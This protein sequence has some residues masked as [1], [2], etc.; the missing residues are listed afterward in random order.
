M[1]FF[2]EKSYVSLAY[3][4][5]F[6][7]CPKRQKGW[8][9]Y[10]S[11]G[12]PSILDQ[13]FTH[14]FPS[15]GQSRPRAASSVTLWGSTQSNADIRTP[16]KTAELVWPMSWW[17]GKRRKWRT[18]ELFYIKRD[19]RNIRDISECNASILLGSLFANEWKTKF[20]GNW[21]NLNV[22]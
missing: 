9:K 20:K 6:F 17:L 13:A 22:D 16:Y 7:S 11:S 3:I 21:G 1:S 2:S 10:I 8:E 19:L 15:P 18:R 14:N 12:F 4:N 5:N